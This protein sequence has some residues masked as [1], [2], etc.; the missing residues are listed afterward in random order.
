MKIDGTDHLLQ[1]L[2]V[3]AGLAA[4]LHSPVALQ[5]GQAFASLLQQKIDEVN[6]VQGQAA[7]LAQ[8]FSSGGAADLN[9]VMVSLSKA[10]LAFR[11]LVVVRNKLVAAYQDVMNMP[12]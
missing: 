3:Q 6:A 10:N 7:T 1:M 12:V 2:R 5:P 9:D 8:Q 4:N 11:E